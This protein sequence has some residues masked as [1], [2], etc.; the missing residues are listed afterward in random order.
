[1][2]ASRN[3]IGR[4]FEKGILKE[5]VESKA[6]EFVAVYG[7]R[8]IGK[9]FLIKQFFKEKFDFYMTGVLDSNMSDMLEY[10]NAQLQSYSGRE[11]PLATS[12]MKAFRQLQEY[13][14][15]LRKK[16]IVVFIDELPWFDTPRSRFFRALDL[17]WNGWG[18]SQN[19]L[20]FIVCGS[21]TTW[22]TN[23]LLGDKGGLHNR[24]TRKIY[25]APFNLYD[26]ERMLQS[27]GIK[28]NRH[29]ITECYM[30]VGGIP[31]YLS[32]MNK[33]QSV[34]QNIDRLFFHHSGELKN[35]YDFLFRSLFKD[36]TV[37]RKVVELIASNSMGMTREEIADSLNLSKGGNLTEV[38]DNL[39]S[40]DFI[41]EYRA[42]GN[43]RKGSLFQLTDLFTLFYI[44]QVKGNTIEDGDYWSTHIDSSSHRSWSGYAFEQVCLHHIKQIKAAIGISGVATQV[45]SWLGMENGKR[46]G[47][48]DLVI[49]RHDETIN[50]CE[51]KYSVKKFDITPSYLERIIE[52]K[53]RFREITKTRKA[54][55]LTMVTVNGVVHNAQWGEIQNEVAAEQLFKE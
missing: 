27:V 25:L 3:I 41:R 23:K 9:T 21:A 2:K 55:H 26:T 48:I 40:C 37:Y 10:F 5:C 7:R 44:K 46:T 11:W 54:L 15:S 45:S 18:D 24:V 12:W 34:A 38:L 22:M 47:Q 8:R 33:S 35:E 4:E 43:K 39:K 52:R 53:E 28:W 42:F 29:Q 30:V 49:D 36:S 19:N 16:K 6:P 17:F 13:L 20:L 51:M 14:S 31:F 32:K 50:L 1:M